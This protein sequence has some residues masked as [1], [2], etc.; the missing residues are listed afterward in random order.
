MAELIAGLALFISVM[1]FIVNYRNQVERRHG[2]ITKLRSD[3]IQRLSGA[4]RSLISSKIHLEMAR[5]E[6][7][8]MNECDANY[9]AI[10]RLPRLIEKGQYSI[11]GLDK[12]LDGLDK[13]NTVK[14]N[15][16]KVLM[17]F[18]SVEHEI[19]GIENLSSELE[20]DVLDLLISIRSKQEDADDQRVE[21][22][23]KAQPTNAAD[24]KSRAAD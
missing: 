16:S 2:E 14:K 21:Q 3:F 24:A 10:E 20:K 6:L 5:L 9:N 17:A 4:R 13:L 18:Q 8:R 11:R 7:R 23:E 19:R 12:I 15:K 1:L 22:L